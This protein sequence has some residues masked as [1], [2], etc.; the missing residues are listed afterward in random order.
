MGQETTTN[1]AEAIRYPLLPLRDMVIFPGS[2]TSIFVGREKSMEATRRAMDSDRRILLAT[3]RNAEITI[4]GLSDLYE[5]AVAGEILQLLKMPDNTYKVLI[6]GLSRVKL[7]DVDSS[8]E[9]CPY[10]VAVFARSAEPEGEKEQ[11]LYEKSVI[12]LIDAFERLNEQQTFLSVEAWRELRAKNQPERLIFAVAES[13]RIPFVELQDILGTDSLWERAEKVK[14]AMENQLELSRL[15]GQIHD[16]VR[17]QLDKMQRQY[18]LQEQIKAIRDEMGETEPDEFETLR[19]RAKA[20]TWPDD[21]RQKAESEIRKLEKMPPMSAESGVIRNYLDWLLDLPFS[22]ATTDNADIAQA[23]KIL[24]E[25]HYGLEK[26]KDRILEF[27]AV[28]QL[29][30]EPRGPILCLSGPPGVGKTSLA[31]SLADSL[32]R[33]FVRIALGGV[34]D[35]A[36]IRG[37]RRTYIGSMPGRI[38]A[39]LKKAKVNNPVILLD[40]IDKISSDFR[41]NPAAALLE[42]LDPEQNK[43]FTDHY[44]DL[45]FD[46]SKALF[47]ATA[48]V[49]HSIPEPLL[50]RLEIIQLSGYTEME[51]IQIANKY[52]IPR[53]IDEN[54][55]K[56]V[57]LEYTNKSLAY[58]IRHY[59]KEAGVRQFERELAQIGRKIAREVVEKKN[60][61]ATF[62]LDKQKII[63]Y[64]GPAKYL[65]TRKESEN[66]VGKVS[67]LA[68]TSA[69][70]DILNIEVAFAHGKGN[71]SLT[72]NLG[73]VMKESASTALGFVRS[74]AH[75]LGL[76][77]DFF[78]KNDIFIHVPEGA[79]PKDGPSAGITL[80]TAIISAL[81]QRGV[82]SHIAMTGEVTLRGNVLPIGGLKEKVLAAFRGGIT[83]VICPKDNQKDFEEIPA[84]IRQQMQFSFVS[85]VREVI[86]LALVQGS[87]IF[88]EKS[89]L[90]FYAT[91]L[92]GAAAA[93][94]AT[95]P[96]TTQPM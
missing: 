33:K 71:L 1:S 43:E 57:E 22:E 84:S 54:G 9:T 39:A 30:P 26:I 70:G 7:V 38:I 2:V 37:H 3:Q 86:V 14:A 31:R 23:E 59:T 73:D 93:P 13:L 66:P 50:D 79:I 28:R 85:H 81:T 25:S 91:H 90:A 55:I 42:V 95:G 62:A 96:T 65:Y 35:E 10:A 41:G 88:Q 11:H 64:L 58:I 61:T 6:E 56:G 63:Q 75:F 46:L 48:N 80:V 5:T 87:S 17:A 18:Y 82:L 92:T 77:P 44:L 69:G 16:K 36:E 78:E 34:R 60:D 72:G 8:D 49:T 52:L 27:I 32:G 47:V 21:I 4:P 68:W 45:P 40:E 24:E 51:K 94:I 15:E 20:K 19:K 29:S 76:S 67:G 89:G 74:Q 12:K 83:H 53:Q